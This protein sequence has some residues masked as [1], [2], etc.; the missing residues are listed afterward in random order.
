L[1]VVDEAY[2]EYVENPAYSSVLPLL[3]RHPNLVI[4]R[5]FSK[6]YGLA[7]L[8]VGY[9]VSHPDVAN[10]LNRVRNPFNVDVFALAAAQAV[11]ADHDYLQRSLAC[12]R[13]GMVQLEKGCSELGLPFIPSVG[14]FI[15]VQVG[16]DAAA[17]YQAL[18]H[19]GVI[20]RPLA[21][22]AMPE[23]LRITVGTAPE[24]A[25]CLQALAEVLDQRRQAHG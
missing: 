24:N 23:H 17:I 18:L 2:F 11:L 14:N 8:R 15:S 7:A 6:A 12:N 16:S 21:S 5:T 22:Y 19:K 10:V 25:R 4:T 13:D 1:I 9:S 20:V 3:D